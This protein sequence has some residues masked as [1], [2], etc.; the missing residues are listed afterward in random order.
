MLLSKS[1]E[2]VQKLREEHSEVFHSD[3]TETVRILRESP[4][5]LNE[6]KYTTAVITETL[7]LFPVGF[8]VRETLEEKY[9]PFSVSCHP[10]ITMS[11]HFKQ[12]KY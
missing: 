10:S 7:R 9:V 11:D 6:L 8:G 2:V 3:F 12:S 1:P 4:Q 5:K